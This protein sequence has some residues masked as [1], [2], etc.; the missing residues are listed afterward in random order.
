MRKIVQ[1]IA[2]VFILTLFGC[3][4]LNAQSPSEVQYSTLIERPNEKT[5]KGILSRQL[6]TSDT[7]FRWYAEAQKIY[8][9]PQVAVEA[10]QLKKDSVQLLVFMGTWCEDSHFIIPRLFKLTDAA[11]FSDERI[12][13]IGVD[14]NKKTISHLCDAL[15][16]TNVPTIIVMKKGKET[17]RVVEYGSTGSFDKE[18]GELL[19]K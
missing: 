10:F 5:L 2:P 16:V 8:T 15:G 18:L 1:K 14:R 12:T 19:L 17:G 13:L 3:Q 11:G 6:L 9:P 7:L 4:Y